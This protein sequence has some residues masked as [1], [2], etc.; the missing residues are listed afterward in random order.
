ML[1]NYFEIDENATVGSFLREI[2][3]KKNMHY[4]IL[5]STPK[6][7]VDI[8]TISLKTHAPDEKLKNLK[9]PLSRSKGLTSGEHLNHLIDSGDRV[10]ETD[11][12]YFDF[13][14]A[15]TEVLDSDYDFLKESVDTFNIK[16]IF[17]LNE[18]DSIATAKKLFIQKRVNI[19][20]VIAD[21]TLL[22]EVRAMDLLSGELISNS[23]TDNSKNAY[24]ENYISPVLNLPV[25][26]IINNRPLTLD[27]STKIKDAVKLMI[28]KKVPS[29]IITEG[30]KLHSIVS[31]KDIFKKVRVDMEKITYTIEYNGSGDMYDDEFDLVQDYVERSMK[32][33]TKLSN[34]DLLKVSFKTHGNTNGNH[35]KKLSA[36]LT[37]SKGNHI[38]HVDKEMTAGTSDE[39]RNDKTKGSWNIP[40]T[41]Q[42]ALSV[43]EKK[44]KEEKN[45][46]KR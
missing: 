43:L 41:I 15:L 39:I 31:Y 7:F 37:L 17:A 5:S 16:E 38:L 28:D 14:D 11:E 20:P 19:L 29:L 12:G 26:N 25:T 3:D 23:K 24:D 30:D 22:G 35:Q 10:V 45:K 18:E 42:Q 6:T 33:I 32:K 27:K 4:I 46:N 1:E 44:V 2:N 9:K 21:L 8:R 40:K 34:Y 13:I 36:N